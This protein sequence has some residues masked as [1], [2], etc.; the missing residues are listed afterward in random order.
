LEQV[1]LGQGAG[2]LKAA[3]S[4]GAVRKTE[5]LGDFLDRPAGVKA[6]PQDASMVVGEVSQGPSH[7]RAIERR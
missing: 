1:A 5:A 7:R 6:K 2:G 4:G 3:P